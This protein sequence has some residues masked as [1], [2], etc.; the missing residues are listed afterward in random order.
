M[1]LETIREW[2]LF[3]KLIL[4]LWQWDTY[5]KF[6][7]LKP[8]LNH[9]DSILEL[10]CGLGTVTHYFQQ[11]GFKMIPVDIKNC[12][13]FSQVKPILYDG[14]N[15]P[16]KDNSFDV[17]LL[18][19]VLHH[20]IDVVS[21]LTEAKRVGKKVMIIEDIYDNK[22]QQLLTYG[23]D[24]LVN[25]EFQGHPHNNRTDAEWQQLFQSLNFKLLDT[26][27]Y[28]FLLFFKQVVYV[29]ES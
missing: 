5:Q 14:K 2:Q 1:G 18:L 7:R 9:Q 12:S 26:F 25:L 22:I 13:V 19:T 29:L 27:D 23:V 17:V 4:P 3:L 24:S 11:Q 21:V 10:G 16:F 15:L 28:S 8:F 6:Q 20:T